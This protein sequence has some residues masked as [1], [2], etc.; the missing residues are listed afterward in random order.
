MLPAS[1]GTP[2]QSTRGFSKG[3][4]IGASGTNW[5]QDAATG[6]PQAVDGEAGVSRGDAP[7]LPPSIASHCP[8]GINTRFRPL[9]SSR[10]AGGGKKKVSGKKNSFPATEEKDKVWAH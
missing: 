10:G 2:T 3:D 5:L 6:S 4:G 7:S 8:G 9:I 1:P